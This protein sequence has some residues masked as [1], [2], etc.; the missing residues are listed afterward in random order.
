M[1]ICYWV[2]EVIPNYKYNVEKGV[3]VWLSMRQHPKHIDNRHIQA[4][5]TPST[6]DKYPHPNASCKSP[7]NNMWW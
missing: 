7:K 2:L 1:G 4:A 5:L 6:M 3:V